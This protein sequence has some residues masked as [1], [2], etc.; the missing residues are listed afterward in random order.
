MSRI[1]ESLKKGMQ[2][3]LQRTKVTPITRLNSTESSLDDAVT[4][5][6]AGIADCVGALKFCVKEAEAVATEKVRR[7]NKVIQ[8]L[9][10]NIAALDGRI[11]DM[12]E[13]ANKQ[14]LAVQKKEDTLVCKIHELEDKLQKKTKITE[15]RVAEVTVLKYKID[16]QAKRLVELE[17]TIRR[18]KEE[19]G[20]INVSE[21]ELTD[22][23]K[24]CLKKDEHSNAKVQL[25]ENKP[26][27]KESHFFDKDN[28]SKTFQERDETVSPFG[29]ASI[30]AE[31]VEFIGPMASVIVHDHVAALGESKERFPK[32]R[33]TELLDLI[34]REV[35][36]ESVRS[37][38]RDRLSKLV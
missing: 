10:R 17:S 22:S 14:A 3:S 11:K 26:P 20:R 4:L 37:A 2:D 30:T 7:A 29:L 33:V 12:E 25:T 27:H 1:Y 19:A 18:V 15:S 23:K 8:N 5:F 35:E 32:A 6:E 24:T 34:T 31:L 28:E 16:S 36:D 21:E 38:L 9:N 13:S